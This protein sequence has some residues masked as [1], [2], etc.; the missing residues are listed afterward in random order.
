MRLKTLN[1][2]LVNKNV[3]KYLINWDGKSLSKVQFATKQ[4]FKK[5]WLN[6]IV[7]EEF[8]VYGTRLKVDIFN[9]TKKIA[10]EVQGGQ[11]YDYNPFFHNNSRLNYLKGMKRDMTKLNWLEI[12]NY[13]LIEIKESEVKDLSKDFIEQNFD[14]F[15]Y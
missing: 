9:A 8:P 1:G 2:K 3:S 14:I 5:F 12:N 11:H 13:K 15:L 10:V 6:D 4:F 7:Y